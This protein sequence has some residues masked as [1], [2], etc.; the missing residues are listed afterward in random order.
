MVFTGDPALAHRFG[1]ALVIPLS[2]AAAAQGRRIRDGFMLATGERDS[3]P[4]QE[5][6]GHLGG[7]DV[8]VTLVDSAGNMAADIGRIVAQ[9]NIDIVAAFVSGAARPRIA[10]H[11]D[12]TGVALLPPGETPFSR[13]GLPKV[14]AFIVGYQQAYGVAPTAHAAR[15]YNAAR[16]IASAVRSLGGVEDTTNLLRHFKESASGF[17]W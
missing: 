3:H 13:P 12:G 2:G 17:S 15:G 10:K 4:D 7:L 1:V 14:A 11:F 16:R 8:Y 5:S 6:D 9:G